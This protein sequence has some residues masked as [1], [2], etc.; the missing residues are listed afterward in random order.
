MLGKSGLSTNILRV[1]YIIRSSCNS[2]LDGYTRELDRKT[3]SEQSSLLAGA[4]WP[5]PFLSDDAARELYMTPPAIRA[6]L[7]TQPD[8]SVG[9]RIL[10][11]T[12]TTAK[13][14]LQPTEPPL[15]RHPKVLLPCMIRT[16]HIALSRL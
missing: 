16:C 15:L 14:L 4:L 8:G 7:L 2:E 12:A 11:A 6:C 10:L 13:C 5:A 1:K 9:C 3:E